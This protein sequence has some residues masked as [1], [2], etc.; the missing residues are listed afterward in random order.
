MAG[1]CL[2]YGLATEVPGLI[3]GSSKGSSLIDFIYNGSDI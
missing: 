3:S 2:D 1:W